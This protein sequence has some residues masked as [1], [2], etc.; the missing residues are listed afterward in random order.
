M[1]PA[2]RITA[3]PVVASK[4]QH[5]TT[6]QLRNLLLIKL[7]MGVGVNAWGAS[8]EELLEMAAENGIDAL[9]EDDMDEIGP[10]MPEKTKANKSAEDTR[11]ELEKRMNRARQAREL[12]RPQWKFTLQMVMVVI[13]GFLQGRKLDVIKVSLGLKEAPPPPLPRCEPLPW[14]QKPLPWIPRPGSHGECAIPR[15]RKR[16]AKKKKKP[17]K[18]AP[19]Y[20]EDRPDM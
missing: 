19:V 20:I 17:V 13:I 10:A 3:S 9:T 18:R 2:K 8:R 14:W 7:P 12:A 1:P 11:F 6:A 15:R 4:V 16:K 5:L